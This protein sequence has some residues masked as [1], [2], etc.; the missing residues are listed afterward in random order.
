MVYFDLQ[1]DFNIEYLPGAEMGHA[2]A[3]TRL[4]LLRDEPSD[5][6]LVINNV[7]PDVSE[8]WTLAIQQA[9]RSDELA[10][11]IINR[12]ERSCWTNIGS[13]E[14]PF[15]RVR[16]QLSSEDGILFLESKCYIPLPLRKDVFNSCHE[17]HT[18]AHSTANRI[19]LTGGRLL[20]RM[21]DFGSRIVLL[22][23][24]SG[25]PSESSSTPGPKARLSSVFMRTGVTFPRLARCLS[26]S[27]R[28]QGGSN[29]A[30]PKRGHQAM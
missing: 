4:Q 13:N 3:L 29:A 28:L 9:T 23:L 18:G 27:M 16:H 20:E 6:D 21:C 30:Y 14:R 5:E 26:W 19:K 1:F 12:V 7:A 8:D 24:N 17:L 15:F 25:H 2:D 10:Q 22:A 11:A